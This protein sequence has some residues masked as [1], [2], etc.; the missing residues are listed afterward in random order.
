VAQET[1][2]RFRLSESGEE[3]LHRQLL[4]VSSVNPA[5][6][7]LRDTFDRGGPEATPEK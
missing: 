6:E 1:A 7:G 2:P 3:G 4:D 5:E